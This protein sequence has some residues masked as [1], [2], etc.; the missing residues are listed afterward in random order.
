M[1]SP[2]NH[3]IPQAAAAAGCRPLATIGLHVTQIAEATLVHRHERCHGLAGSIV[4]HSLRFSSKYTQ[5]RT[6]AAMRRLP[7]KR[8]PD[9]E[10]DP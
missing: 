4:R 5:L 10:A 8:N 2:A 1:N 6:A 3:L 7:H 9:V